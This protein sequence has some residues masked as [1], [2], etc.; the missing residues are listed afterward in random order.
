MRSKAFLGFT[1]SEVMI[2]MTIVG[3]VSAITVPIVVSRYQHQSMI[4]LLKKNYIE[5]QEN[6]LTLYAD[7]FRVKFEK[8]I[9]SDNT[10]NIETFFKTYYNVKKDCNTETQPCFAD[11]YRSI[12][13]S[14]RNTFNCQEGYS[15]VVKGGAAICIIPATYDTSEDATG[16][17]VPAHVYLDVNGSE[18]PNIGGRDMF[19]FYIY[20]YN[21][22]DELGEDLDAIKNATTK[23]GLRAEKTANCKNSYTGIG[24]FAKIFN[25][26]WKMNY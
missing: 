9:L 14:T 22:I 2:A 23:Q 11:K 21:T 26:D 20:D 18:K 1:V 7:N 5:M 8:S 12:N 15:V 19:S 16:N 4:G 10:D 17:I 3:V 13:S 25:D 6:L 24:C